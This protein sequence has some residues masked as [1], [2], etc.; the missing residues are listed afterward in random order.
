MGKSFVCVQAVRVVSVTPLPGTSG[1]DNWDG[2][3]LHAHSMV[4]S[5]PVWTLGVPPYAN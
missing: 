4:A 3:T 2:I 1:V 5:I